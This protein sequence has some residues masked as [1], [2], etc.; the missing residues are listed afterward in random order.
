[1]KG[2]RHPAKP[3]AARPFMRRVRALGTPRALRR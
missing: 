1:M 3:I 2:S